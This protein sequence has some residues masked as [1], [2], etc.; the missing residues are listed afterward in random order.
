MVIIGGIYFEL[1]TPGVGFPLAAALFAAI[2]YFAPLYLE[3]LAENW[4]LV[5]FFVGIVLIGVEIFAIP[6]FGVAGIS[7]IILMV[8]GLTLSMVDNIVFKFDGMAGFE[9]ILK[10]LFIVV[11]SGLVSFILSLYL[12]KKL[13]TSRTFPHLAL[14]TVQNTMN[15][16]VGVESKIQ[17]ELIGK[18]GIAHTILRPSGKVI[19]D[20]EIYD[21]KSETGYVEKGDPVKVIRD[22]TGQIYVVPDN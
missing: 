14:N 2:L 8:T 4:E 21:A 7:G 5:L 10:S 13:F 1:Q 12:S 15:G 22:E 20:G 17:K 9:A 18:K 6:G 16:F 11:I 19:I 3:G